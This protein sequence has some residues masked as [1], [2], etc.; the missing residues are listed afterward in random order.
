MPQS[1]FGRGNERVR[2]TDRV[3]A[4][5]D[6]VMAIVMTLMAVELLQVPSPGEGEELIEALGHE[7]PAYLAYTISFLIVG[8]VWITHHNMWRYIA[9]VDQVLLF[10][11]LMLLM[12]V[13]V[14][15]FGAALQA[16][17]LTGNSTEQRLT[18]AIYVGAILGEALFFSLSWRWACHR[19]LLVDEMDHALA[20][21]IARR[22]LIGPALY[23]VAFATVFINPV[24]SLVLYCLLIF[25]YV[26]P[27]AGD[28]PRA[29]EQ[30]TS[31]GQKSAA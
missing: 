19:E 12:F 26:F 7:W 11:N 9:R 30:S 22:Y 10:M 27:G 15:P 17:N 29:E 16:E 25:V 20:K 1:L 24:L 23:L 6:A 5:S 3:E 14:I 31:G 28:L 8:Q 13:A 18:A 4:F 21:A 2:E